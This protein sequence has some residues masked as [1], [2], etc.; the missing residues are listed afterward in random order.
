MH[1]NHHLV[2]VFPHLVLGQGP[3]AMTSTNWNSS[4]L[5][6]L[7]DLVNVM[8][9]LIGLPISFLFPSLM[10]R[11]HLCLHSISCPAYSLVITLCKP[12]SLT[13]F[14]L[15]LTCPMTHSNL[16]PTRYPPMA[17]IPRIFVTLDP[18]SMLLF[19]EPPTLKYTP[20]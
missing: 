3:A 6:S 2:T 17:D 14:L 8:I 15:S 11:L 5:V 13:P 4:Q 12:L 9:Q 1:L 20:L 7:L 18:R 19:S 16:R 10:T